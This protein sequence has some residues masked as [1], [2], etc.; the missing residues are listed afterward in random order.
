[1]KHYYYGMLIA[2][3]FISACS[4][5]STDTPDVPTPPQV[6]NL[7]SFNA[8]ISP[9]ARASDTQF[10]TDDAIGVFGIL[11]TGNDN[12]GIIANSGNYAD[13]VRYTYN[14]S[15][16]TST[17]PIEKPEDG[18]KVYYHAVYPYTSNAKNQYTF[19]VK[20]DQRGNG[21][22]NS[23]LCTA[24]TNATNETLV[25][26]KF[27]HRLSKLI[28]NLQG[29]NWGSGNMSLSMKNVYSS[30]NADLNSLSFVAT[31]S[32]GDVI[33]SDNGTRSFKVILPP[34]CFNKDAE[35]GVLTIG[36]DRYTITMTGAMEL[37]SGLQTEVSIT[38]N[39]NKEIV[40]FTGDINPW[41]EADD[42][43]DEVVPEDIQEKLRPHTPTIILEWSSRIMI[44]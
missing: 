19:T 41:D 39:E 6:E 31:G 35:I 23:D 20:N 10:D 4:S 30:V 44:R 18:K 28:I 12:K 16:F 33:C 17:S 1:M 9:L 43:L 40:E 15:K 13:N 2:A 21:Y 26:L 38:M 34:Q 36:N 5:D 27:S 32:R 11:S 22:T 7:V 3:A 29:D 14:G 24:S 25:S 8:D 42:R 37:K